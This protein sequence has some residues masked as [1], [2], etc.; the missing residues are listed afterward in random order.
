MSVPGTVRATFFAEHPD[1]AKEIHA[2]EMK[3]GEKEEAKKAQEGQ[4]EIF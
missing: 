2:A 1:K 4:G 3:R